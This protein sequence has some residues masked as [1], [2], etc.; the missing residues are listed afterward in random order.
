MKDR[1]IKNKYLLIGLVWGIA[2][3]ELITLITVEVAK[4]I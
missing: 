4:R 3:G 2:I 1:E